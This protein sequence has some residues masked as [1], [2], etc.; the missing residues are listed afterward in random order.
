[1]TETLK[2]IQN[3]LEEKESEIGT[4]PEEVQNLKDLVNEQKTQIINMESR[5]QMYLEKC[6]NVGLRHFF[7]HLK[8]KHF[9]SLVHHP[10]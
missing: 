1:M 2:D 10:N 5:Y 6:R 8:V 9:F 4:N 7:F 3:K